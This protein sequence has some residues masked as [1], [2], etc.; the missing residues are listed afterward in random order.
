M[1]LTWW[2]GFPGLRFCGLVRGVSLVRVPCNAG[3]SVLGCGLATLRA[4]CEF[5]RCDCLWVVFICLVGLNC[6]YCLVGW[7][8]GVVG[9]LVLGWFRVLVSW[10][11]LGGGCW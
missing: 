9:R 7:G 3:Y 10:F 1:L 4:F 2:L 5:V 6:S 11:V 8:C